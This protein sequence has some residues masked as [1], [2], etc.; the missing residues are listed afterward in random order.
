MDSCTHILP[1]M[2]PRC[3]LRLFLLVMT[4]GA[5]LCGRVRADGFP[6]PSHNAGTWGQSTAALVADIRNALE[7]SGFIQAVETAGRVAARM[8]PGEVPAI[9]DLAGVIH[10]D[11]ESRVKDA[12]AQATDATQLLA[13]LDIKTL[14]QL[15]TT[16]QAGLGASQQFAFTIP[17][18]RVV[19]RRNQLDLSLVAVVAGPNGA[20][21]T[22][23]LSNGAQLGGN[24]AERFVNLTREPV[25]F[26][27]L[28]LGYSHLQVRR[29]LL[30]PPVPGMGAAVSIQAATYFKIHNDWVQLR[31]AGNDPESLTLTLQFVV[32]V[33]VGFSVKL[34]AEVE[35]QV[36]LELEVRPNQVAAM[37]QDVGDILRNGLGTT[38]P[39]SIK[40]APAKVAPVLRQ[41]FAYLKSV[42]DSGQ[43]LGEFAIRFAGD[44]GI[45]VGIW[46]TGINFASVG[47]QL[48][49]SVP[50]EAMYSLQGDV[51]AA[52]L[53]AGLESS[54]QL[55]SLFEAMSEGRLTGQELQKQRELI[56]KTADPFARSI[57]AGYVDFVQDVSLGLE[58]NLSVLGDTG[59]AADETTPLVVVGVDIPVGKILVDGVNSVPKFVNG[60]TETAKAMAW[61]A[62]MA[63]SAG[64]NGAEALSLGKI[65]PP[66]RNPGG[67]VQRPR[68]NPPTPPTAE[69]WEAMAANLLDDVHFSLQLGAIRVD[70]ASL[71][72]LVRLAGGAHAVT[73]S[74]L[75]GAIR[76]AVTGNE[77]PILDALRAA[78]GQVAGEAYDLLIFNLQNLSV[79]LSP[80]LGASG[81]IGAEATAGVGAQIGFEAELKASLLLLALGSAEYDETDGTLLAGFDVPLELSLSAGVSLGEAVEFSAEAG[82]T[83]GQSLANLTLRDWGQDLPM[84]AGLRIAGFE[85]IDF[86]GTNRQDGSISGNGWMVLPMGGLV[87]A[88]RFALAGDGKLVNGAWS[89]V[90][91]LGPL[92]E[93]SLANGTIAENG[94]IGTSSL[95]I[96]AS[97]LRSDF[98]LQSDGLMFGTA[99]GNL[100]LGGLALADT[101]LSLMPD[102]SFSGTA[103]SQIA[104][105][106]S[107]GQLRVQLGNPP[108]GRMSNVLEVAGSTAVL[109]LT[110]GQAGASGVATV[111]AFGQPL[112][113]DVTIGPGGALNGSTFAKIRTPWGLDLDADLTLDAGGVHGSG[114]TRILGAEFESTN[115][116]VGTGGRMTGSFRGSIAVEGQVLAFQNLEITGDKLQGRTTL[117]VAGRDAVELLVNVDAG[118]LVGTFVGDLD[119]FGGG[120]ADAWVRITDRIEVFGEMDR[121][122][123]GFLETQLRGS[124][125]S[126]ISGAQETLRREREK[127]AGYK[128]DL[129]AFDVEL[130]RL[131]GEITQEKQA[132]KAAAE[133]AV[134]DAEAA[135]QKANADLDAA[136]RALVAVSGQLSVELERATAAVRAAN[137]ALS[138]ARGE[139]DKINRDIA[140]LDRWYNS[141]DA[142]WKVVHWAGY[143]GARAALLTARNVANGA[144]AVAQAAFNE[145]NAALARVQQQLASADALLK[146]KAAKEQLVGVAEQL[147]ENARRDLDALLAILADPTLDPRHVAVFL[148]R[149]AV[150]GL[151]AV[152]EKVIDTTVA[153]L[154]EA[155]GLVQFIQQFGEASLVKIERV[156]F[157]ST[158][159]RMN[160]GFVDLVVDALVAQKPHRFVLNFDFRSGRNQERIEAAARQLAPALQPAAAW[161]VAP[162][163]DDASTGIVP[164]NTLWAYQFNSPTPA[165]VNGV[166]IPSLGGVAPAVPG[167][168]SVQGFTAILPGDQNVLTAG[169]GGSAIL[170]A[171][172]LYGANPATITF[173]GLTPGRSYRATF[174]S[175]GWDDAPTTRRIAFSSPAGSLTVEQNQYGNNRGIRIEHTFQASAATHVVT[176]TPEAPETFHL[177]ALALSTEGV[178]SR[179][180]FA[181]WKQAEFGA[182]SFNPEIA[183]DDADPD[184]DRIPN[185]L[186]Y[187]LRSGPLV[188][189]GP[190]FGLPAPVTLAGGVEARR[191]VL[192]YQ[193]TSGDVVYRI[194]QSADLA[195]WKDAFRLD[196]A[197][198]AITQLPGVSSVTDPVG[199]TVTVTITDMGLF[200][201][202]SFWCLTVE[203]R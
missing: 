70:G 150:L 155:A 152:A 127:L 186:E 34:Q 84:P 56:A 121:D 18:G 97:T 174:L 149:Q 58:M 108:T 168:F 94:L 116:R 47:A 52:Q 62:E 74:V 4:L 113:F 129:E 13:Q 138:A 12:V 196:L 82:V 76:S 110:L 22:L 141:L 39:G 198:G 114:R 202:P 160:T 175:V 54:T 57:L 19:A 137:T 192:P 128:A 162:W 42:E 25:V 164:G 91:E 181:D 195:T 163:D 66:P 147:V 45:G 107:R 176:L 117:S 161:T 33:K 28:A 148:A 197:T 61:F 142:F 68:G 16:L 102:G 180:T 104:G 185:V 158:L 112:R 125:L 156:H 140:N 14:E 89:G 133:A 24:P 93:V 109:D 131:R 7:K 126:G 100:N 146:D 30:A 48:R 105:V 10:G 88:D 157:R 81:T 169:G 86:A 145:A 46:D 90:V 151:I 111:D 189:N 80:S 122:F 201:P 188:P 199:G 78:P 83:V 190:S 172:F 165:I 77:K 29:K 171:N 193:P 63:I 124:L 21:V 6:L 50:L 5:G 20:R 200:A 191:F 87:R 153:A 123:I 69:E 96:G 35:G 136:I 2:K 26:V 23:G 31:F 1:S 119:L 71:G 120:R 59:Q 85:V 159:A 182:D 98:R 101:R 118:G 44:G 40:E 194:R 73:T 95:A 36:A 9:D 183:G 166:S 187:A 11:V 115:L 134:R 103:N 51:L 177:Y 37:L 67:F 38:L 92:G 135:L 15:F 167:K 144:L 184:G 173:E 32:G 60:V 8:K 79:G 106:T 41:V 72:N 99:T 3:L 178:S 49:L 132:A 55:M 170:G 154:G 64:L 17:G 43:E 53:E 75:T 130:V 139:V 27:D 179:K 143:Q 65:I 203:K